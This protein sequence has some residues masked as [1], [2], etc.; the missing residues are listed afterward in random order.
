MKRSLQTLVVATLLLA[1]PASA[2]AFCGF[3]VGGGTSDLYNNATQVVLMRDGTRTILSMQNNYEG[4]LEAFAMVVPVPVVLQ[5]PDVKTLPKEVFDKIDQLTAPRLVEYWEQDPCDPDK[6][7][8]DWGSVDAGVADSSSDASSNNGGGV[9]VEAEFKVGEYQIVILSAGDSGALTG[10]L[11]ANDYNLPAGAGPHLQPY[12]DA[13][14]Y[15]F[16]A[17]VIADEVAYVD[18]RA[19]LSPLRFHYDSPSFN[20]PIRLGLIS[21][22]DEQDLIV[23]TLALGQRFE[24]ANYPNVTVP[25]NVNVVDAVRTDFGGFYNTLFSRTVAHTPRAVV[26]EYAWN[27]ASCDPCPGPVLQPTDLA[28]LGADVH[29]NPNAHSAFDWVVTRLHARYAAGDVG[30]DLVLTAASP[31][32]GGREFLNEEALPRS[33]RCR[34]G[35]TT[36]RAATQSGTPGKVPWSARR[37]GMA[38]GARGPIRQAARRCSTGPSA[39]TPAATTTARRA[40]PSRPSSPRTFLRLERPRL[41][42]P[43][44]TQAQV[45][46]VAVAA[47]AAPQWGRPRRC[48]WVC[49]FSFSAFL[50]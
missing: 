17:K 9:V 49:S 21:A 35:S 38:C 47:A 20:L 28:T 48:P 50:L 6:T 30:E 44:A 37:R 43:M 2:H 16:V 11:E 26:T 1:I 45:V 39:P 4:P 18:G 14:Q 24:A 34:P 32:A 23:Y 29:S 15:F 8:P 10:W 25:T 46:A 13:G 40:P 3:Y 22:E 42:S 33:A 19:L 41:A 31:I 5:E 7:E 12:I 27:T 36:S